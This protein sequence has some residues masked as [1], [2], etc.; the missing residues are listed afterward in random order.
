[1]PQVE[2]N[3]S[4]EEELFCTRYELD[5]LSGIVNFNMLERWVPGFCNPQTHKEH[6]YRYNWV[7]D[8]CWTLPAVRVMA[9]L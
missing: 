3:L 5:I 2:Q 1:M 8:L 4:L 6:V 7:K 9:A